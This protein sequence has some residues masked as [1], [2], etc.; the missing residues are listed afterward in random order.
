MEVVLEKQTYATRHAAKKIVQMTEVPEGEPISLRCD[1]AEPPPEEG[2]PSWLDPEIKDEIRESRGVQI[3]T[4]SFAQELLIA[5]PGLQLIG[6]TED[7]QHS[8]DLARRH[9]PK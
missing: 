2:L 7:V 9:L 5:W 1:L 3:V 8:F 6:A 4:P